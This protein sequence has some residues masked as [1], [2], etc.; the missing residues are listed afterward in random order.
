MAGR[1]RVR[2]AE[3]LRVRRW[4]QLSAASAGMGAAMWGMTLVGPQIGTALADDGGS[5]SSTADSSSDAG[6]SKDSAGPKAES[7][8]TAD[9]PSVED[10][11]PDDDDHDDNSDATAEDADESD[12][13]DSDSNTDPG[14]ATEEPDADEDQGTGTRSYSVT[15]DKKAATVH[16]APTDDLSDTPSSPKGPS[17]DLVAGPTDTEEQDSPAVAAAPTAGDPWGLG[18]EADPVNPWQQN[19]ADIIEGTTSNIQLL[20]NALPAPPELREALTGTL[21]TVRRTLFNLA[22]TMNVS[23]SVTGG[24]GQIVGQA[25][26]T[27][28]ENDQIVYRVVQ[29]PSFGTLALNSDGSYTYTPAAGFDGVDTFAVAADDLGVHLNLL[30]PFRGAG[31]GASMLVNQNAIDFEFTYNDPDGYFSDEAKEALYQSARRLSVYF[32]V[33]QKT[34][35]TYTVNSEYD[36]VDGGL[37]GA[38]SPLAN[39]LPGFWGTVVHEKLMNG[40]DV[41]GDEAD[42]FIT[43]NWANNWGYYPAVGSDDYD[44]TSTVMHELLHSFGWLSHIEPSDTTTVA[45]ST[46]DQFVTTRD[47]VSPI[48][49]ET[50]LWDADYDPYLTGYGGGMFFTGAN[51]VAAYG[52]RPVPLW[53]PAVWS[54]GSSVMHLDDNVFSGPNHAMMDH[55]A[56]GLGADN[57]TLSPVE[58]GILEDLGY[59]VVPNPW[60]A[61]P[62]Y[63][64][65]PWQI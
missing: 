26:A 4:L 22:P 31:A 50:Y 52:G 3:N 10:D 34:I 51:A 63:P 60:F 61:Y 37:A 29:G 45:W 38:G 16:R 54:E 5:P 24:L 43:W 56:L 48:N 55:A 33:D 32:L 6:A 13:A 59:T 28:P 17:A 12:T 19:S 36:P 46:F 21:W 41:N 18:Q 44:F 47:G 9:S 58:L 35:L 62:V 2:R 23:Y 65:P 53:T 25:A 1:H 11:D 42:G 39:S 7:S 20:I 57:I 64:A 49:A 14:D 27:D 40:I 30:D 8:D 15:A